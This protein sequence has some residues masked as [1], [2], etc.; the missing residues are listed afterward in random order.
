MNISDIK[1][2]LLF[3][4]WFNYL[5]YNLGCERCEVTAKNRREVV[6]SKTKMV[7]SNLLNLLNLL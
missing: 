3:S 4:Y 2:N 1:S 7:Y 5:V 6:Y